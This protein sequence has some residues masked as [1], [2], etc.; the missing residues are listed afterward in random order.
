MISLRQLTQDDFDLI[1]EWENLPELWN[2]SEQQGPF[3]KEEI[4]SFLDK[5]LDNTNPEIERML[6]CLD[7]FPIGAVDLFNF[8]KSNRCCGI[9][10]FI[11]TVE[12]RKKGYGSIALKQAIQ[13][14]KIRG[15]AVISCII[16]ADNISSKRLFLNAGFA[17]GAATLFKGK[18]AQQ[19]IWTHQA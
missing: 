11:T 15:C 6:I 18:P 12:N 4:Q 13:Q 1:Y 8:D 19:F 9:G 17:E 3:S 5:C 14:L 7:S 10:I 16:Y 2:V